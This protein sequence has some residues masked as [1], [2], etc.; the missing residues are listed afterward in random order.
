MTYG[1]A[2]VRTDSNL[3]VVVVES[4]QDWCRCNLSHRL[5]CWPRV[6]FS[7]VFWDLLLSQGSAIQ[8]SISS[9]ETS[10]MIFLISAQDY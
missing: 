4:T 3:N 5:T 8:N 10:R 6:I 2:P 7:E 9:A 1:A